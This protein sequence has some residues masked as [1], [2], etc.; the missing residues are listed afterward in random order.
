MFCEFTIDL[1][2]ISRIYSFFREFTI[3]PQI[4]HLLREFTI[5]FCLYREFSTNP[6]DVPRIHYD[7]TWCSANLLFIHYFSRIRREFSFCS[8]NSLSSSQIYHKFTILYHYEFTV[9]FANSLSFWRIY[10]EFTWIFV[11]HYGF[12]RN[13]Y[14]FS[15]WSVNSLSLTLIYHEFTIFF[16]DSTMILLSVPW[17]C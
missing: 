16:C 11:I 7:S 12:S 14:K 15:A 9:C 3:N 2:L 10:N 8:K 1:L 4:Y 13:H 5:I 6:R 17:I